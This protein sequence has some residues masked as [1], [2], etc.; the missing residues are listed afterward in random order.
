M[1]LN[2]ITLSRVEEIVHEHCHVAY[3]YQDEV[4]K[5][6]DNQHYDS[7]VVK[8]QLPYVQPVSIPSTSSKYFQ[9]CI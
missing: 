6:T 9:L 3:N 7:N 1:H 4:K 2:A 8:I 5:W